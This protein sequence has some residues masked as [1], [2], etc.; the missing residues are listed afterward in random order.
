MGRIS[1]AAM[2][3][4]YPLSPGFKEGTTS[5]LAAARAAEDAET[6]RAAVLA[7]LQ[8]RPLTADEVAAL[9]GLSI[10]T[11]RPRVSELRKLGKVRPRLVD[12]RQDRRKN[13]SGASAIVWEIGREAERGTHA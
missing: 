5:R 13:D 12:G 3:G 8:G 6:V 9:L 4:R 11:V 2:E 7:E 10:L 1:E